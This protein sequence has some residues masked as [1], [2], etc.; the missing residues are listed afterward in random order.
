MRLTRTTVTGG[1]ATSLGEDRPAIVTEQI[2]PASPTSVIVLSYTATCE[3]S[4]AKGIKVTL[5]PLATDA[6]TTDGGATDGG[7]SPGYVLS[8][9]EF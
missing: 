7:T 3:G 1:T 4:A 8:L 6:G 2:S 9:T 5:T